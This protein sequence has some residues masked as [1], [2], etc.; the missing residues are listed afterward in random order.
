MEE[1]IG[2]K[3]CSVILSVGGRGVGNTNLGA[4]RESLDGVGNT[5]GGVGA[6]T[7]M[8]GIDLEVAGGEW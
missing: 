8:L 1:R 2:Y 3:V 7:A 6:G 5:F 4:S